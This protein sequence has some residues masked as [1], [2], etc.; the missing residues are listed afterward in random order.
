MKTHYF[1]NP[2]VEKQNPGTPYELFCVKVFKS[3]GGQ[4]TQIHTSI[5]KDPMSA[6]VESR[7][8]VNVLRQAFD[9]GRKNRHK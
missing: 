1:Y 4:T 5:Q 3:K 8:L 9:A 6:L 2:I 7:E